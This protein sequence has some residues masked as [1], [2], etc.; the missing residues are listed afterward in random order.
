MNSREF[1]ILL[2]ISLLILSVA[3]AGCFSHVSTGSELSS[4]LISTSQNETH[5]LAIGET[6][7]VS[8]PKGNLEVTVR[9]FNTT[10][11]K[12]LIEEKNSGTDTFQY[13]P[14]IWLQDREKVNYTTIYC[15]ADICPG[16]VFFTTLPPQVTESRDLDNLYADFRVPERG[17]QGKLVLYWSNSGQEVSWILIPPVTKEIDARNGKKV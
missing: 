10:T 1:F 8:S 14:V 11:G 7:V 2:T 15:H 9:A 6:A 17:R 5:E 3:I 12:I 13:D 16:Y 4:S